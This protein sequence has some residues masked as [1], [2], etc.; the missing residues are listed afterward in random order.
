MLITDGCW[1]ELNHLDFYNIHLVCEDEPG[2]VDSPIY[3]AVD[4]E[5]M[6][7]HTI[8]YE[9]K[10]EWKFDEIETFRSTPMVENCLSQS[11]QSP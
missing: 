5:T 6:G 1:I 2:S 8:V 7:Q 9:E 10:K 11:E 3:I 4:E